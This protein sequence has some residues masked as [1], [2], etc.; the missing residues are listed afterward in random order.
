MYG[1]YM[2]RKIGQTL[3]GGGIVVQLQ[4]VLQPGHHE[5]AGLRQVASR[6]V[7]SSPRRS[8]ED[9]REGPRL[10]GARWAKVSSACRSQAPSI[11]TMINAQE[12][13]MAVSEAIQDW[14]SCCEREK[15]TQAPDRKDGSP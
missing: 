12:S 13:R 7:E 5:C 8:V 6:S 14:L 11:P 15:K 1:S 3:V 10:R 4:A 9:L 2:R